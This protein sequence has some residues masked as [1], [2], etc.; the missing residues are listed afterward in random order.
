MDLFHLSRFHKLRS[1]CGFIKDRLKEGK[2]SDMNKL[3]EEGKSGR[4][5]AALKVQLWIQVSHLAKTFYNKTNR[6]WGVKLHESKISRPIPIVPFSLQI[7]SLQVYS[8]NV[9]VI[10]GFQTWLEKDKSQEWNNTCLGVEERDGSG[11]TFH[12]SHSNSY[13]DLSLSLFYFSHFS[14]TDKRSSFGR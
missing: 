8:H 11:H 2:I 4:K 6:T 3:Y 13:L 14:A 1:L 9:Y 12:L 5:V 10:I 7:H